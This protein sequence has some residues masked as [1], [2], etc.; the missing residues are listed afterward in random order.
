VP[1]AHTERVSWRNRSPSTIP[2]GSA[3]SSQPGSNMSDATREE[4]IRSLL[5]L[6]K[7]I[8]RR[9]SRLV[10]CDHD[11]LVGDGSI[12]LIRAVDN[13]DPSRGTSLEQYARHLIA[14]AMLN[15]IR[16]MDH[17]SE[18]TRRTMRD[19]E[20]E[21]YRIAA[22]RGSVPTLGEMEQHRPGF[23]YAMVAVSRRVPLS[24]D[25]KL[26]DG[27]RLCRDWSKDPARIVEARS[28]RDALDAVVE[29]LPPRQRQVI[30]EHYYGDRSLR[31]IGRRMKISA[32][33]ASQLHLAAMD[34]L[35]KCIDAATR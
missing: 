10:P 8:A 4:Q 26:P 7:R 5:P 31:E 2:P 23:T 32:Q 16:R 29:A 21:R 15:G 14:G 11:D 24:L 34:K 25:R 13:F 18:R 22:E 19:G 1:S 17:V 9:V 27:E 6:V 20:A 3:R 30:R 35:R 28:E 12:G 33:R